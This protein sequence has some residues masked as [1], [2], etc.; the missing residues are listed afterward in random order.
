MRDRTA[1]PK[2]DTKANKVQKAQRLMPAALGTFLLWRIVDF[3]CER[4]S[5]SLPSYSPEGKKKKKKV[6]RAMKLKEKREK[7]KRKGSEASKACE[8]QC[9]FF[10]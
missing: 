2:T 5:L 10:A 6:R 9:N 3:A 7:D 1:V 8:K 4:K